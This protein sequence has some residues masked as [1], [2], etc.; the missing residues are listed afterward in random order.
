MIEITRKTLLDSS[1]ALKNFGQLTLYH[2][3]TEQYLS[4]VDAY[5][6]LA[7]ALETEADAF[8]IKHRITIL[9]IGTKYQDAN[10]LEQYA[11]APSAEGQFQAEIKKYL[12]ESITIDIDMIPTGVFEGGQPK[13]SIADRAT[14]K[15]LLVER[16]VCNS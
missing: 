3:P 10:G 16:G 8:Q 9:G 13:L 12:D 14:L 2:L 5:E 6:K 7:C 4:F 1:L 15:W 11:V